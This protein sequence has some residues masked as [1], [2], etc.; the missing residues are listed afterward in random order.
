MAVNN[1]TPVS[2]K[3]ESTLLENV[4]CKYPLLAVIVALILIIIALS[5]SGCGGSPSSVTEHC[6]KPDTGTGCTQ[7]D[8]IAVEGNGYVVTIY[9]TTTIKETYTDGGFVCARTVTSCSSEK[10]CHYVTKVTGWTA[11]NYINACR[12]G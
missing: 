7:T 12:A 8:K 4:G 10:N 6:T 5:I 11:S 9:K 2:S 1:R 3:P